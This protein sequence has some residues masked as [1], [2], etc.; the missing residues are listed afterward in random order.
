MVDYF[1]LRSINRELPVPEHEDEA[2]VSAP[3]VDVIIN[4]HREKGKSQTFAVKVSVTLPRM[5]EE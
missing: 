2:A 1:P 5:K 4:D 3:V